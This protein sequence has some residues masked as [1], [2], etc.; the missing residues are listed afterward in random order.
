MSLPEIATLTDRDAADGV[1]Q[2]VV[3]AVVDRQGGALLLRRSAGDF[4]GGTW[5]LPSGKVEPGEDL[6]T[7]LHREVIEETGLALSE[8]TG[9]LGPFDYIS[10]SG[11]HTRQHTWSVTVAGAEEVR[12]GEHDAYVWAGIDDGHPVSVEV[13]AVLD[14]HFHSQQS[15]DLRLALVLLKFSAKFQNPRLVGHTCRDVADRR[16]GERRA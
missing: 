3:G 2:Q 9:Y 15:W 12:L 1:Q 10:G 4:R 5:E 6:T 11:K 16:A 8:V 7:A 14:R 13:K